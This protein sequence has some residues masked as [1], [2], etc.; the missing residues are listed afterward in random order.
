MEGSLK[1]II[2]LRDHALLN[3]NAQSLGSYIFENISTEKPQNAT[4]RVKKRCKTCFLTFFC[5]KICFQQALAGRPINSSSRL[6]A[7]DQT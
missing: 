5:H 1:S 7:Y 2:H 4:K 6:T 3:S